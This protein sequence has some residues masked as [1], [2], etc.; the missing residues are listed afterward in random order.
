ME[1]TGLSRA[2]GRDGGASAMVFCL[3][4]GGGT[5]PI[6]PMPDRSGGLSVGTTRIT[7]AGLSPRLVGC[8]C[9]ASSSPSSSVT[10]GGISL[11]MIVCVAKCSAAT[12]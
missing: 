4:A 9:E 3:G 12:L 8:T 11:D 10:K 5:T 6:L 1:L 7:S 2:K